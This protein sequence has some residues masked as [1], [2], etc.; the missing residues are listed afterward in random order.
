MEDD[1]VEDAITI[2]DCKN[3]SWKDF[4]V[5]V[6]KLYE[7]M[8][9]EV[10]KTSGGGDHGCDLVMSKNGRKTVV[11]AKH[12]ESDVHSKVVGQVLRAISYYDANDGI[13]IGISHFTKWAIEEAEKTQIELVDRDRL[14]D[15]LYEYPI[16]RVKNSQSISDITIDDIYEEKADYTVIIRELVQTYVC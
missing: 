5:H 4:E 1:I 3:M 16:T 12:W 13:I 15:L 14:E 10:E 8:G 9:Y 7:K 11:D 6:G 2:E